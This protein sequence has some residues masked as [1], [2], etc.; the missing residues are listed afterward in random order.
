LTL[1]L[2]VA[3][4]AAAW[5]WAVYEFR[6]FP[7]LLGTALLAYS[8]GLRH[9]VD[10]DHIAA[11]DNVTRRL[12]QDG[13]R[14]VSV[15]LFF[16]LGHST[17]VVLASVAVALTATTFKEQ[18]LQL[19]MLG[20]VVGTS[21][22]ATFLLGIALANIVVL[23]GVIRTLRNVQSGGVYREED[24]N[25][26]LAGGGLL[27][28]L[29]GPLFRMIRRSWHMFPL[30]LLFGLGFDTATEV[31]KPRTG[32]RSGRSWFSRRCSPPV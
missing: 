25:L 23:R 12:M 27:A 6:A 14:P 30:G 31:D 28:R 8:F 11:I 20:G 10:A 22:S 16:S 13:Q 19:Q 17:V 1:T 3:S 15:G 32:C 21:I 18:L 26:L 24:A 7:L 2:L 5:V 4:N 29:C 9:A